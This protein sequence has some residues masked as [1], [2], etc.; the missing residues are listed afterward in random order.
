MTV[1]VKR[2]F[3]QTGFSECGV[4]RGRIYFGERRIRLYEEIGEVEAATR[5]VCNDCPAKSKC[6]P[7]IMIPRTP[8]GRY[9]Y[10]AGDKFKSND[11]KL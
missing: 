9:I 5:Q 8:E 4:V 11:C 1:E 3:I 2:Q 7:S 10:V 6:M